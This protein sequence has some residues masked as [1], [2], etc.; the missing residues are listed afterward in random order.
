MCLRLRTSSSYARYGRLIAGTRYRGD[1]EARLKAVLK[2]LEERDAVLFIDEIHDRGRW[3]CERRQFPDASNMLSPLLASG[4]LR[5][6]ARPPSPS[7]AARSPE[8]IA[9]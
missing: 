3:R 7:T 5:C 6:I 8:R 1:F 4:E 2:A 9:R